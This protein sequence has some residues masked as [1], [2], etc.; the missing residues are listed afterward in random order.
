MRST[1]GLVLKAGGYAIQAH[2]LV[3]RLSQDL[4]L[5]TDA[6]ADMSEIAHALVSGLQSKGWGISVVEIAPS[7]RGESHLSALTDPYVTISRHTALVVLVTRRG[8]MGG[9]GPVRE[10]LRPPCG[11]LRPRG[12]GLLPSPQPFEL[13]A[14]PPHQVGVDAFQEGIQS[15]SVE[16]SEVLHP[17]PNDGVDPPCE[18]R[19]GQAGA[20]VQPPGPHLGA[21]LAQSLAADRG[22]ERA[23][24]AALPCRRRRQRICRTPVPNAAGEPLPSPRAADSPPP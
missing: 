24:R 2:D 13:L 15:R 3:A 9:P 5:A 21:N 10:E 19:L 18:V 16:G 12:L 11:G 20:M 8:D 6:A 14:H 4:D 23:E 1:Y 22:L 17:A 7:S